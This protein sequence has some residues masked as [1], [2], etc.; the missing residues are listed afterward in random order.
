M[1][2]VEAIQLQKAKDIMF[3]KTGIESDEVDFNIGRLNLFE[4]EEFNAISKKLPE[5]MKE[6]VK[7]MQEK[8]KAA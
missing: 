5:Q 6:A 8:A 1:K 2:Q 4:D 3:A 7:A